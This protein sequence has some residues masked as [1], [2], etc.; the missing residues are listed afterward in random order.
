LLYRPGKPLSAEAQERLAAIQEATELG[1][2]LQVAMR[3]LEIRGAGNI[4]GAEQSGHIAAIG[5]ELYIRLLGQAVDEIRSGKPSAEAAPVTLDLPL[6][7][8]I[9]A[10]YVA[11]TELRLNTY[12]RV[13]GVVSEREL[14]EV[15][16]ELEDRFGPIPEQVEHLLALISLRLR[17]AALGIE[18]VIER[19]REIV[20]R[21][22]PTAGLEPRLRR[23]LGRAVKL[24]PNAIRLRL[25][26]LAIPWQEAVDAVLDAIAG[27]RVAENGTETVSSAADRQPV[28]AG[29]R[30][31]ALVAR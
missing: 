17:A 20:I 18:S 23:K 6:T 12:R 25:P 2:G 14:G 31:R 8:L 19:E 7:A 26:D 4:L 16:A 9:P 30:D 15:R 10:D 3:D 28:I 5:Y 27:A 13:A 29:G 24:T 21:P 1:A 11:D 22:V